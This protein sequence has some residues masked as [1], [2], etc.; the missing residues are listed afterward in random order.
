[1]M[2]V[3]PTSDQSERHILQR[4]L[5][6]PLGLH[7]TKH[8]DSWHTLI[9]ECYPLWA[10]QAARFMKLH[11]KAKTD[12][13]GESIDNG[14]NWRG[15]A[16]FGW[17]YVLPTAF[18]L[19]ALVNSIL[20]DEG[21][22]EAGDRKWLTP[23]EYRI[24]LDRCSL[25]GV[26]YTNP[27]LSVA[28][29]QRQPRYQA[30]FPSFSPR[31]AAV[32]TDAS[33]EY[34]SNDPSTYRSPYE[35]IGENYAELVEN[36]VS[37]RD[38]VERAQWYD[39]IEDF[40]NRLAGEIG[41]TV[42]GRGRRPEGPNKAILKA[43]VKEGRVLFELC[44]KPPVEVSP[45]T[46]KALA[47]LGA[48]PEEHEAWALRLALPVLSGKEVAALQREW[49]KA[50]SQRR[51]GGERPTALRFTVWS[52]AHRLGLP[53]PV[54]ARKALHTDAPQYFVNRQNPIHD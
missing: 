22:P 43:L 36:W 8:L 23:L 15:R 1:M 29:L 48:P 11:R 46:D 42:I 54:V 32:Q 40:R 33:G 7:G 4:V 18:P 26:S 39:K 41:V 45:E 51:G 49:R 16:L 6:D 20:S 10:F 53:A 21:F 52:L 25:A 24:D 17:P 13:L 34:D 31:N 47:D 19:R 35:D 2:S 14:A 28:E 44:W 5:S 3:G 12:L 9:K 38:P 30:R 37:A 27:F 50:H